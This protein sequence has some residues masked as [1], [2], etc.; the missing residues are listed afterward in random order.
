MAAQGKPQMSIKFT[1]LKNITP[2]SYQTMHVV[3]GGHT[4][5]AFVTAPKD[6]NVMGIVRI[7]MEFGLLA[8]TH[9]GNYVQ[10]NGS[11]CK[12]LNNRD[13]EDAIFK[14]KHF[15]R[16]ESY[17]S[18]RKAGLFNMPGR[19]PIV[20]TKRHRRIDTERAATVELAGFDVHQVR[21]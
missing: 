4:V 11:I 18:T 17:L 3:L 13:V 15:G 5:K 21:S 9:N 8:M 1:F 7:G 20:F 16:G 19:A 12:R 2:T 14:A 6:I 10:V